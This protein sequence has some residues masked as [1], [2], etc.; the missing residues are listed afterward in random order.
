MNQI[1]LYFNNVDETNY[2]KWSVLRKKIF[3][4]NFNIFLIDKIKE[5]PENE[6]R[7]L[8]DKNILTVVRLY[9]PNIDNEDP[10]KIR[11]STK[12]YEII[13]RFDKIFVNDFYQ[14]VF[15]YTNLQTKTLKKYIDPEKNKYISIDKDNYLH[16][17]LCDKLTFFKKITN[18]WFQENIFHTNDVRVDEIFIWSIFLNISPRMK[19]NDTIKET[20]LKDF[21]DY[22]KDDYL[23]KLIVDDPHTYTLRMEI[24]KKENLFYV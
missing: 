15:T 20:F 10:L 4:K 11:I 8:S 24:L 21:F 9:L 5:V 23:Y 22:I 6:S 14:F 19:I 2:L 18:D 12:N 13:P 7:Q 16:F 1:N 3:L 17:S